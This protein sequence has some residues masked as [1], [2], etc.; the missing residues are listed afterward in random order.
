MP[1]FSGVELLRTARKKYP[2]LAFLLVTEVE[3]AHVGIQAI[4]DGVDGYL[5]KPIRAKDM[6]KNLKRALERK[7]VEREV[8]ASQKLTHGL[9]VLY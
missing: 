2:R 8:V 9:R 1:G 3:D 5:I 4:K 7:G 6:V